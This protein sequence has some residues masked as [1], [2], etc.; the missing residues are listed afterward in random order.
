M[1]IKKYIKINSNLYFKQFDKY[2]KY[3]IAYFVIEYTCTI[4]DIH[5]HKLK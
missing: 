5:V 3:H 2:I 4:N 1:N